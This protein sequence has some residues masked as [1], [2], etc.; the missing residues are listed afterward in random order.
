MVCATTARGHGSAAC[1]MIGWPLGN[2]GRTIMT[3]EIGVRYFQREARRFAAALA[4]PEATQAHLL[5]TILT[6]NSETEFGRR[7]GFSGIETPDDYRNAV[8]LHTYEDLAPWIARAVAGEADILFPGVPTYVAKTSGTSGSPKH[9]V[10]PD[11]IRR[12]YAAHIGPYL[13]QLEEEIPGAFEQAAILTGRRL[14]GESPAGIPVCSASGAFR[15]LFNTH[16]AFQSVPEDVFEET[17]SELRY[18]LMAIHLLHRQDLVSII[19]LNP[20]TVLT[21]LGQMAAQRDVLQKALATGQL[22]QRSNRLP[23]RPDLAE[24]IARIDAVD[25]RLGFQDLWPALRVLSVWKSGGASHYLSILER[26]G[27]NLVVWPNQTAATEACLLTPLSRD[28]RGGVPSIRATYFDFFPEDE[29]PD[30]RRP[31]PLR[32]LAEGRFYRMAITNR[33][34]LYR[35]LMSDAFQVVGRHG[36][37]P[38]LEFSHRMGQTSSLTGEKLTEAQVRQAIQVFAAEG[39]LVEYQVRPQLEDPPRY[40]ILAELAHGDA[41]LRSASLAQFDRQLRQL[42]SEY[43]AKRESLRLAAPELWVI[44][45]GSFD[46]IRRSATEGKGRSDA[47]YKHL[48][49]DRRPVVA[50]QVDRQQRLVLSR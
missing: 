31:T 50:D 34:G 10:F 29:N 33:R 42:N 14:E 48:H 8:P 35:Y 36:D 49:L 38:I 44:A 15:S 32:E 17:D 1:G 28:W 3:D 25:G 24:R 22:P 30:P 47:Q 40:V 13:W 7:L 45:P 2:T 19:A 6:E 4:E 23:A 37:L 43:D 12:E 27:P 26:L 20:S 11:G 9:V 39:C 18:L 21:L 5:R 46:R 16:R 41:E